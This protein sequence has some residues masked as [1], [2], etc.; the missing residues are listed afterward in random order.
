MQ[1]A[2][3]YNVA[4]YGSVIPVL[5]GTQR[6]SMNVLDAYNYQAPKAG[7]KGG[8]ASKGKTT[9][10]SVTVAMGF[11]VGPVSFF[12]GNAVYANS[13]VSYFNRTPINWYAGNDGQAPDPTFA[14]SS[15]LQPVVGYSG[16]FYGTG[17][18]LQLAGG[19]LPN[20]SV[21]L[22][23][24]RTGTAG[25][26]QFLTLDANPALI[27]TDMLYDPRVGIGFPGPH[28]DFSIWANFCQAAKL[29]FSLLC[30][31][32]QPLKHWIE[33]LLHLTTSA[34]VWSS[35]RWVVRPYSTVQQDDNGAA[36]FPDLTP[37]A[38]L[39]DDD[40]LPWSSGTHRAAGEQDPVLVTRTDVS[41][42]PNWLTLEI[43]ER[44]Y[45]W[46]DP[47]IQPPAF[48]QAAIELYGVRS[49]SSVQAHE[50]C[51]QDVGGQVTQLMIAREFKLRNTFKFRLGWRY[52]LLEP[53]DIVSIT[54]SVLGLAN[55]L[56]RLISVEED[57]LGALTITA[58]ELI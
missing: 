9:G 19:V 37:V 53:M 58:E 7:G 31:K 17:T 27:V 23:G 41:Q 14:G 35:G 49:T 25:P 1:N 10:G 33:E 57:D 38:N 56:V 32:Q 24:F 52:M 44:T 8:A 28:A 4:Q 36:Y 13:G 12:P 15:P 3:R 48:D 11:C 18:P 29:G 16:L 22:N 46:Y 43:L 39:T 55:Y 47:L 50:V 45:Y 21:E 2:F 34:A 6:V 42:T 51:T 26:T 30:D 5:W 20:L 54:D 40:F